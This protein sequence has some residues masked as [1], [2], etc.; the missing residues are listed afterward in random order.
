MIRNISKISY[1]VKNYDEAIDFFVHKLHFKLIEDSV[2]NDKK[3]WVL[4][5]PS[6]ENSFTLLLA[7]ADG[8]EQKNILEIKQVDAYFYF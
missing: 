4:V 3:R 6:I 1:L 7:K 5:A 2:L 8:E